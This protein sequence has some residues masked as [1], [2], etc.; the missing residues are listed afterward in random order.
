MV[1][2]HGLRRVGAEFATVDLTVRV[3]QEVGLPQSQR[4]SQRE[5]DARH[6]NVRGARVPVMSRTGTQMASIC[7]C[8]V[9][10][11]CYVAGGTP[12]KVRRPLPASSSQ[13]SLVTHTYY[14]RRPKRLNS[15]GQVTI[16]AQLRH[17]MGFHEGGEVEVVADVDTLRIVHAPQTAS[18]GERLVSRM[19]GRA[20]AAKTADELMSLL[21]SGSEDWAQNAHHT[22]G[23]E[24]SARHC[25]R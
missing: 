17:S 3:G 20:T 21:R 11:R 2:E 22:R 19:R 8:C 23:F 4:I 5:E 13:K 16:A 7:G 24:C 10:S 12:S 25:H 18:R 14:R 6:D 15:K 1:R 9:Q